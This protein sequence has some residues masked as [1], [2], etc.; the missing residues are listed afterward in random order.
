MLLTRT[1]F[2]LAFDKQRFRL[3]NKTMNGYPY[4]LLVAKEVVEKLVSLYVNVGVNFHCQDTLQMHWKAC[5]IICYLK[6]D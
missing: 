1:L 6:F 4:L 2:V 3:K 5:C